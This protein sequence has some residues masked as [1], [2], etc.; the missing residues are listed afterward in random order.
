[1]PC[2]LD[3]AKHQ[4]VVRQWN[5]FIRIRIAFHG[6]DL[7]LLSQTSCLVLASRNGKDSIAAEVRWCI[8]SPFLFLRH[9]HN[10]FMD[11]PRTAH[12]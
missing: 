12:H 3:N 7:H 11:R 2:R 6:V 4:E 9:A 5:N 1:M 8:F 10:R